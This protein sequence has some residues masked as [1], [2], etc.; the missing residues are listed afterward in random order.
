MEPSN[1]SYKFEV[2]EEENDRLE[3]GWI[4]ALSLLVIYI[5]KKIAPGSH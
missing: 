3:I 4:L 1:A 5:E 2:K